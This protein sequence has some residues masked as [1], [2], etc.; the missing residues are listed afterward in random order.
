MKYLTALSP[1]AL[2][3]LV[4]GLPTLLTAAYLAFFAADHYVSE[5]TIAVR[6]ASGEVSAI[7]GAALLLSGVNPPART[8][9]LYLTRYLHSLALLQRLDRELKVR[10]HYAS[11]SLDLA[12]RLRPGASQERFLEYFRRRVEVIF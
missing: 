7:S 11:A 10:E 6:Q 4:I 2:K 1:R 9:T 5:A 12:F 8:D 3:L